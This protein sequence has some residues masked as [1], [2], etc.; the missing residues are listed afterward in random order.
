MREMNKGGQT[1][2]WKET[3]FAVFIPEKCLAQTAGLDSIQQ[4]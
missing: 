3:S 1:H 2:T 4:K